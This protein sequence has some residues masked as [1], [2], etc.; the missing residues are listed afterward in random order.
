MIYW[1]FIQPSAGPPSC[2]YP[3]L[4]GRLFGEHTDD[5]KKSLQSIWVVVVA[6]PSGLLGLLTEIHPSY[7]CRLFSGW[8][9]LHT[10][11][12]VCGW[13]TRES[14]HHRRRHL[15]ALVMVCLLVKSAWKWMIWK[16]RVFIALLPHSTPPPPAPRVLAVATEWGFRIMCV[17]VEDNDTEPNCN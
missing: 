14:H 9:S 12:G 1:P 11:G 10:V 16:W 3:C 15:S 6:R 8:V 7:R 13:L 17:W 5:C 2:P 4:V